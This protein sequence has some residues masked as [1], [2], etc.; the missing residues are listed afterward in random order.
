MSVFLLPNLVESLYRI[1]KDGFK[2]SA[3]YL[4]SSYIMFGLVEKFPM[5]VGTLEEEA[6]GTWYTLD[7]RVLIV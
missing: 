4:L 7:T 1:I 3:R 6:I 2:T 5:S